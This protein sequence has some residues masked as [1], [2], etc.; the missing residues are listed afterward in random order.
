MIIKTATVA[1]DWG[2][3]DV[4]YSDWCIMADIQSPMSA[5]DDR[6]FGLP[7]ASDSVT[8][9]QSITLRLKWDDALITALDT[10][11]ETEGDLTIT[12]ESAGGTITATVKFSTIPYPQVQIGNRAECDLVL[13]VVDALDWTA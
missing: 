4:D 6:T 8:G 11:I 7:Y 3:G 5:A 1:I 10:V 2:A 13:A 12:P 9:A